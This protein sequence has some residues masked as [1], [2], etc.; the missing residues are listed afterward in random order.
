[1]RLKDFESILPPSQRWENLTLAN[2]FLFSRIMRDEG[3]CTEMIR[4]ILPHINIGH[5]ELIN[6]FRDL[7]S[8]T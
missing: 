6:D 3:L 5:I 4:R 8:K 7:F 1:M 2:D